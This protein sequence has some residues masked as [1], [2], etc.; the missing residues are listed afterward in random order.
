MFQIICF[1]SK[2]FRSEWLLINAKWV[3]FQISWREQV[4]YDEMSALYQTNTLE[5]YSVSSLKQQ[6]A[7][8]H[9]AP[10]RHIIMIP[11]QQPLR[12]LLKVAHLTEKQH[13]QMFKSLDWPNRGSNPRSTTLVVSTLTHTTDVVGKVLL[14]QHWVNICAE[15]VCN[16]KDRNTNWFSDE[17]VSF[18]GSK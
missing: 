9:V 6:S 12:F 5:F 1:H 7:G 14:Y 17:A 18:G 3:I 11:S 8:R 16:K 4:T 15:V 10:L 2:S 13:S